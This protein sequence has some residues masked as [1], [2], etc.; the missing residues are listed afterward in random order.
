MEFGRAMCACFVLSSWYGREDGLSS[1]HQPQAVLRGFVVH[2]TVFD[3]LC[4]HPELDA[5]GCLKGSQEIEG[6]VH[7]VGRRGV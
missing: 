1:G 3:I 6:Y 2:K 7:R 4:L 5:I